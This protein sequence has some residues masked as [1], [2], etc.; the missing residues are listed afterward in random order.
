VALFH[1]MLQNDLAREQKVDPK[2]GPNE[3]KALQLLSALREMPVSSDRERAI[4]ASAQQAIRVGKF[5]QLHR[6]LNK[7]QKAVKDTAVAPS[8]LLEKV[9]VILGKYPILADADP[10]QA[11]PAEP[12]PLVHARLPEIIISESFI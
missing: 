10:I 8:I 3:K 2:L 9:M 1:E 4:L 12:V 11:R 5:Q 7:L 6:D